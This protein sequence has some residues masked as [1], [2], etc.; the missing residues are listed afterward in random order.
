MNPDLQLTFYALRFTHYVLRITHYASR[1][2][3]Y[4]SR[5]TFYALR[6]TFY[7][8]RITFYASRIN[9]SDQ[10]PYLLVRELVHLAQRRVQLGFLGLRD[11]LVLDHTGQ[12]GD[13][14]SVREERFQRQLDLED[15]AHLGDQLGRQQR[16][17]AQLEEVVVNAHPL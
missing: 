2:T 9:I 1:F 14:R 16:M 12:L 4:A 7:A 10:R 17:P 3:F 13:R 11:L 6:F 8:L 15:R 5:F